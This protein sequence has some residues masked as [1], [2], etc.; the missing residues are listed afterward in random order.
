MGYLVFMEHSNLCRIVL[1]ELFKNVSAIRIETTNRIPFIEYVFSLKALGNLLDSCSAQRDIRCVVRAD[2]DAMHDYNGHNRSWISAE[3]YNRR[4]L[5]K[6]KF[7]VEMK[8]KHIKKRYPL[9][10][11]MI[12]RQRL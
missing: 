5:D 11:L 3:L 9:H 7:V 2:C 1:F 4:A 6:D 8:T 10:E 12:H